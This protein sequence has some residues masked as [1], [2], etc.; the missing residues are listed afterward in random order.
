MA[1][2][3]FRDGAEALLL[4]SLCQCFGKGEYIGKALLRVFRQRLAAPPCRCPPQLLSL[5]PSTALE[6]DTGAA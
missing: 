1:F 3:H 4:A 2:F 5:A 6:T